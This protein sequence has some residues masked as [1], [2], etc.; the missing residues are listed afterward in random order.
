MRF[1]VNCGVLT[2]TFCDVKYHWIPQRERERERESCFSSSQQS[3]S[4]KQHSH[5]NRELLKIK[6]GAVSTFIPPKHN[7]QTMRTQTFPD[8]IKDTH[9]MVWW[10]HM[11][12]QGFS[13]HAGTYN[14]NVQIKPKQ[15]A[16]SGKNS[17][18]TRNY[19]MPKN[20]YLLSVC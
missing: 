12:H 2:Q 11:H 16:F 18:S 13:R 5:K 19:S 4:F 14:H 10:T 15:K 20:T 17:L 7:E 8:T 3:N 1:C 9:G 6:T